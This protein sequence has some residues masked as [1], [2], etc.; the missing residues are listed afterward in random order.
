MQP[1]A[2]EDKRFH[3]FFNATIWTGQERN[4]GS[5]AMAEAMLVRRGAVVAVGSL[6]DVKA[7]QAAVDA[8]KSG[9]GEEGREEGMEVVE[10]DLGGRFVIPGFVDAHVHV[11]GGGLTLGSVAPHVDLRGASSREEFVR[12]VAAVAATLGPE[13]WVLGGAWDEGDWGGG[14]PDTSWLDEAT[15]GRPA[16]LTRHDLHLGLASS[17]ALTL[18][19]VGPDTA[20]PQGGIIDRAP[21][22]RTPT[23]LLRESATLLLAPALPRPSAPLRRS[24]LAAASALALSRGVTTLVDM[25]RSLHGDSTGASWADLEEVYL[26]AADARELE[27]RVVAH[28]PL[29]SWRRA[30]TWRAVY[31]TAH[32][33]GRLF[34]GR[35]KAFSDGSLGSHT[36]LM[37]GEYADAPGEH[38]TRAL[39]RG[40]LGELAAAAVRA[41]MQVAI[42]AIGDRA[43]DEV[44]EA[45]V[46]ALQGAAAQ[47]EGSGGA[48]EAERRVRELGAQLRLRI[49]HAQHLSG[50]ANVSAALAAAGVTPVPNPLHLLTDIPMLLPRLGPER[51]GRAFALASLARAGLRPALA[52]DWPIVDLQPITGVYASVWRHA[53]PRAVS[54]AMNRALPPA[55]RFDPVGSHG[56]VGPGGD[57]AEICRTADLT[58]D[59][60]G[61]EEEE[62]CAGEA[63]VLAWEGW[64]ARVT[65][66]EAL[67]ATQAL[68]GHTAWGAR[69]AGL[70]GWVGALAP[71]LRADFVELSGPQLLEAGALRRCLPRVVRTW[72]DG[73][74]AWELPA[75]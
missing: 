74:L 35:L 21:G 45:Y 32:P 9:K 70:E 73:R 10:H 53:P 46:A 68:L 38:G 72:V 6:P 8:A 28:V 25:G 50:T 41:G 58:R 33:S 20:D 16:F 47:A 3:L 2:T 66:E 23:G 11:I 75:G 64:P 65:A 34:F 49:E 63:D 54:C 14:L 52:S 55:L 67:G 56:V 62:G 29:T 57:L 4:D 37:W 13:E 43:V 60:E 19:G 31:G 1:Q 24:A 59:G 69:A 40:E 26:P 42:H 30:A 71:G 27:V 5:V 7:A 22:S 15:G 44:L 18:A 12:R 39:G 51:A 48:G 17:A 36:A 61:E